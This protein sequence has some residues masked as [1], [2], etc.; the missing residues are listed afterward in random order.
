MEIP[1]G[2]NEVM[3][4]LDWLDGI[5]LDGEP[6]GDEDNVNRL[7]QLELDHGLSESHSHQHLVH[8]AARKLLRD[9]H[10]SESHRDLG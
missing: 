10:L 5:E 1:R 9:Q 6:V 2:S 7:K 4:K 3:W 8:H